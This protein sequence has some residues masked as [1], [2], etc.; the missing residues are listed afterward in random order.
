VIDILTGLCSHAFQPLSVT[1]RPQPFDHPD[2]IFELKHDGFRTLAYVEHGRCRLM[3]RNGNEVKSFTSLSLAIADDL[4]DHSVVLDG[5]IVCLDSEGRSQFYE[6]LFRRGEPRL[7]AFDL[8]WI[9]GE[10]L[11]YT[12]LMDRKRRLR[13]IIPSSDRI[14]YCDHIEQHGVSLF[15][16]ACEHDLEGIVAKKKDDP[17]V[18]G[19]RWLKIRNKDYSQWVGRHELFEGVL[20]GVPRLPSGWTREACQERRALNENLENYAYH[21]AF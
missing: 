18:E 15:Q 7:C 6:L 20:R 5:E 21:A 12:S 16:M 13:P 2:W 4:K 17:Y 19:T 9:D 11:K 1:R 3:S 8:L 10:N 14:F